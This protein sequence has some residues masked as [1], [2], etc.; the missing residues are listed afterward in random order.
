MLLARDLESFVSRCRYF[1]LLEGHN[2]V[3][4]VFRKLKIFLAVC[5]QVELFCQ[6]LD[7]QILEASFEKPL[8]EEI[9][10]NNRHTELKSDL[11]MAKLVSCHLVDALAE[12][13]YSVWN[14]RDALKH[15]ASDGI[16]DIKQLDEHLSVKGLFSL[17]LDS[18]GKMLGLNLGGTSLSFLRRVSIV[19]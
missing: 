1:P 11:L 14:N 6:A 16:D 3:Q 9:V 12:L 15:L 19:F 13:S 2:A 18:A 17:V 10:S 8:I 5:S 7:V 4:N